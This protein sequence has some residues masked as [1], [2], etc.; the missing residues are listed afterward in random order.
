MKE[1]NYIIPQKSRL[2]NAA[3]VCMVVHVAALTVI[4]MIYY[5]N[6]IPFFGNLVG[7]T[8]GFFVILLIDD[9]LYFL[10][11]VLQVLGTLLA[12]KNLWILSAGWICTLLLQLF[13]HFT[14]GGSGSISF[15]F[16]VCAVLVIVLAQTGNIRSRK[17][18]VIPFI[19]SGAVYLAVIL[20]PLFR[21]QDEVLFLSLAGVLQPV[22]CAL[23]MG[24]MLFKTDVVTLPKPIVEVRSDEEHQ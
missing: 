8:H 5:G 6:H 21:Y 17:A 18:A 24:A 3:A 11:C 10:S 23:L 14:A 12:R 22:S 20:P 2:F 16:A 13:Q 7:D 19:V 15:G 9:I 1:K 4:N